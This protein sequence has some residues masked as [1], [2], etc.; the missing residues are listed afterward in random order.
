MAAAVPRTSPCNDLRFP[1]ALPRLGDVPTLLRGGDVKLSRL[2]RCRGCAAA[3]CARSAVPALA[4]AATIRCCGRGARKQARCCQR[5]LRGA[6][7]G[8]RAEAASSQRAAAAAHATPQK[9]AQEAPEAPEEEKSL[10]ER[11]EDFTRVLPWFQF[12]FTALVAHGERRTQLRAESIALPPGLEAAVAAGGLSQALRAAIA[13]E[14]N[15]ASLPDV[16][17]ASLRAAEGS[18]EGTTFRLLDVMD[19]ICGRWE[20][21]WSGALSPLQR[22]GLPRQCLWI[23]VAGGGESPLVLTVH[24]GLPL[25]FGV[26]LWTSVAGELAEAVTRE[27]DVARPLVIRFNR[28][29]VDWG[30]VPRDDIGRVD[31][32]L[33]NS[34]IAA[35]GAALLT[36]ILLEFGAAKWALERVGLNKVFS[37]EVPGP[38]GGDE[39]VTLEA[40]LELYLT[41]LAMVAFPETL[42]TC[43]VPYLDVEAG[44]CVYEIPML[45]PFGDLPRWLHPG[46]N[47]AALV[48]R[49][50]KDNE[51]ASQMLA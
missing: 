47:A 38:G 35:F 33:V 30:R 8:L 1:R 9:N 24:S 16:V 7:R 27:E 40:S 39:K 12:A 23:E 17:E 46:G 49:R 32:G 5:R 26:Y 34:R 48:A 51:P 31:G 6:A 44:L 45:G 14:A 25:L 29:W 10:E 18:C 36:P 43:P 19:G 28:Y 3:S 21:V 11:F 50:L 15:A 37:V 20:I 13:G 2:G 41:L 4:A 22:W 42:S